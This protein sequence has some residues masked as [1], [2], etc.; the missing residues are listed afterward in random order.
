[1]LR[2]VSTRCCCLSGASS[3]KRSTWK[4]QCSVRNCWSAFEVLTRGSVNLR[5][6]LGL[7]KGAKTL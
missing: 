5:D 6:T 2:V 4:N 3:P 7:Q 1:M